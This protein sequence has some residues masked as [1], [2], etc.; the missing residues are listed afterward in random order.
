VWGIFNA[1]AQRR[2]E[3]AEIIFS[4]FSKRLCAFALNPFAGSSKGN[5]AIPLGTAPVNLNLLR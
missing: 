5:G 4:L 1:K 3:F 2:K